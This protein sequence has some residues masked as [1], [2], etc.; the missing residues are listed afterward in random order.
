M[1]RARSMHE[2]KHCCHR[3]T[4]SSQY[5]RTL[6]E[7]KRSAGMQVGQPVQLSK[8]LFIPAL[9]RHNLGNLYSAGSLAPKYGPK[10]CPQHAS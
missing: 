5:C 7:I 8:I 1:I 6:G 9:I 3:P 2:P 10:S 4:F